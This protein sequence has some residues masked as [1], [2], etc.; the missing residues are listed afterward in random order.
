MAFITHGWLFE[1]LVMHFGLTDAPSSFQRLAE[2]VL[3]GFNCKI[4]LV[5]LDNVIIF[6][7]S[8]E[9]HLRHLRL[10]CYRFRDANIKL[11]PSKCHFSHAEVNY[12]GGVVSWDGVRPDPEKIKAVQ[13]FPIPKTPLVVRAFLGLSGYYRKFVR[14]FSRSAAP[15]H[16]LTKKKPNFEWTDACHASFLHKKKSF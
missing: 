4:C 3:R 9:E 5:H 14:D 10:V 8:F 11:K 1:F 16:D 13:D 15:L 12:F 2:C 7:P 6:S